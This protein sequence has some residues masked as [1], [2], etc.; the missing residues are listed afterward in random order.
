M[1]T[2][3]QLTYVGAAVVD[4]MDRFYHND[5][6][7]AYSESSTYIV[8]SN[9]RYYLVIRFPEIPAD[10]RFKKLLSVKIQLTL[11]KTSDVTTA[12][13]FYPLSGNI[14]PETVTW[15]TAPGITT[16]SAARWGYYF[17]YFSGYNEFRTIDA[18]DTYVDYGTSFTDAVNIARISKKALTSNSI[19]IRPGNNNGY[20]FK[21]APVMLVEIDENVTIT[22]QIAA[23]NSPTS[24]WINP[25]IAQTFAWEFTHSGDYPC[26]G[27]FVQSSAVFHWRSG[28]SGNWTNVSASGQSVTIP[29]NTFPGGTIQ[30]YVSG[31]DTQG[32]SSQTPVYTITTEDSEA[33]ATAVEP[34]GTVEDGNAPI[35]FKW[36]VSTDT[37]S[38][39]TGAD[40]QSSTDNTTWSTFAHVS[41]SGTEYSAPANTFAAGPVYW[42]VRAYNRDGVAGSW[43]GSQQFV[44][45]A[46]PPAPA[47]SVTAVPF[48]TISWQ[49]TG[50]QAYRVTIDGQIYGPFFGSAKTFTAPDYLA[51]GNHTASVEVLG[52]YGLWS[53][54]G[55]V[56]FS[57]QNQPGDP[58]TLQGAFDRDADLSWETTSQTADFLIYRDDVQIG[59]SSGNAFTDRVVLGEHIWQVVNRLPGGYYTASNS[60]LGELTECCGPALALLSGGSWLDLEKSANE[61]RSL[62][63]SMSQTVSL[64]HFAGQ[65]YPEAEISPYKTMQGT[66]DVAWTYDNADDAQ[67]FAAMIG[68]QVIY[69][70]PG[71]EAMVGILA[72]WQRQDGHFYQAYTATVERVHWRDFI[73]AD[74]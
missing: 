63:Y 18:P 39:P 45:V 25:A 3:R 41:G 19:A 29:A 40:L 14:D 7:E 67:A 1:S 53:A 73:D 55:A 26:P 46:A 28:T 59:H 21:N 72:A 10:I 33:I 60:V 47:V 42:R 22:S 44:S 12:L 38:T 61:A 66:F 35:V 34:S 4:A 49:S 54:P 48:A 68:K 37:G 6:H 16:D 24:G 11:S 30:W 20:R 13:D 65:E 27:N 50:Q 23:V 62:G 31:T 69:K 64:R 56:S 36:T 58:I 8:Q 70:A 74:D 9:Y 51:D 71:G 57:V 43:S 32:T 17:I 5:Y 52:Q 2:V 15:D